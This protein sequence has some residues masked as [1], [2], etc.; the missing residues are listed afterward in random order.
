MS[1]IR[2]S[3]KSDE[4]RQNIAAAMKAAWAKG[5]RDPRPERVTPPI[6]GEPQ[7]AAQ[8]RQNRSMWTNVE[9]TFNELLDN[10]RR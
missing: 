7:W 9:T 4:H 5:K 1:K 3:H 10:L 6:D 2:G 8:Q